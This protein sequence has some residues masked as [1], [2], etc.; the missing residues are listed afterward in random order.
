MPSPYIAGKKDWGT[1]QEPGAVKKLIY[2][3]RL[4][5]SDLLK[6]RAPGATGAAGGGSEINTSIP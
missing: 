5:A 4:M 1:F 2:V 6:G 3:C